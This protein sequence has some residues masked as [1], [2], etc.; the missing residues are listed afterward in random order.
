MRSWRASGG[1]PD[2]GRDLPR[3]AEELGFE[4]QSMLP[5][6]DIIRP[7]DFAWQWPIPF[8]RSGLR[9][10]LDLGD[11]SAERGEAIA[12]AFSAIE[13]DTQAI[14]VTPAVLE[15]IASRR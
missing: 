11:I 9:R 6:V 7:R 13:R 8:M 1:E 10:L 3:W 15:V 5:I 4:I 14:M 2:I 12:S